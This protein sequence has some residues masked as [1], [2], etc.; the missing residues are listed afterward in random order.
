RTR[1]LR[2]HEQL[3]PADRPRPRRERIAGD[4]HEF[5][6]TPRNTA[7]ITFYEPRGDV[8]ASGLQELDIATGRVLFEWHALGHIALSESYAKRRRK[9]PFDYFHINSVELGRDGNLLVS[10]RNTNAIYEI[11]RRT[12]AVVWRLGGK[13]TVFAMGRGTRFAWQPDGRQRPPTANS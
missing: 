8:I 5:A 7:L 12:G 6:I 11:D 1:Q 10:A 4:E 13:R 2:D 9:A 3:L